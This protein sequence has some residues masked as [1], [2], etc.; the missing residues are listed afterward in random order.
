MSIN[1]PTGNRQNLYSPFCVAVNESPSH[2]ERIRAAADSLSLVVES[3]N[4]L[5]VYLADNESTAALSLLVDALLC[6]AEYA[7]DLLRMEVRP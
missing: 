7:R 2:H 5:T 4:Q 3:G 6:G 1:H